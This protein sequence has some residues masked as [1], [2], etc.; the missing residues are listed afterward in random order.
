MVPSSARS[1]PPRWSGHDR[2][3][4]L[5]ELLV[6]LVVVAVLV[7]LVSTAIAPVRRA[8]KATADLANLRQLAIASANYA[9]DHR[10]LLVDARLPHGSIP[11][12]GEE[13]FVATL[14]EYAGSPLALRS[15]LDRSRHWREEG[16]P[17]PGDRYRLT[18]YGLN[19]HLC[20]E[21]SPW[22]AIDPARIT[23]RLSLV[24]S[25]AGTVH[26]LLMAEAGEFAAADH[27]HVEEWGAAEQAPTV[28]AGQ[29]ATSLVGGSPASPGSR[30]NYAFLDGHV[31][32]LSFG[33]VYRDA[34]R[35][36]FDPSCSGA[37]DLLVAASPEN[38]RP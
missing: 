26:F 9:G 31:A 32:T 18:S 3:F 8:A 22:G 6:V 13:S 19:N 1:F 14:A 21:F 7:A 38:P 27:V 25:P 37:F 16:E 36:R 35:N 5:V 29:A 24:T 17:L 10:G 33:E 30:S 20:R 12:D 34:D 28:A 15:P 2:G 23:D 4:S 11:L